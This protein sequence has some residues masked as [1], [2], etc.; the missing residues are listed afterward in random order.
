MVPEVAVGSFVRPSTAFARGRY[1]PF[2][3]SNWMPM[4][5]EQPESPPSSSPEPEPPYPDSV[6]VPDTPQRSDRRLAIGLGVGALMVVLAAILWATRSPGPP[7]APVALEAT[8]TI[9]TG[10]CERVDPSVSLRWTPPESGA[11][12]SGYRL[13]RD[14]SPLSPVIHRSTLSFVDEDVTIGQ[15]YEYQVVALSSEG[16]SP[17]ST[18]IPVTVPTPP[19]EEAHLNGVYEV[20]LTVRRAR[21]I[22]AAFG[23]EDPRR[24]KTRSDRWSFRSSCGPDEGSCPSSWAGLGG[25]IEPTGSR[26]EGRVE[27]VPARCGRGE[28][29]PAPIEI[30]LR[31]TDVDVIDTDWTVTGFEGIVK[32]SFRC[33]GFPKA[34]ATLDVSGSLP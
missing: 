33:P 6:A 3:P 15:E 27:G 20:E 30:E 12:A 17:P 28:K 34:T 7:S 2:I 25:D 29:A 4:D 8:P 5:P 13:I 14:G 23:I 21:S 32:V 24:G 10:S 16:D 1:H 31:A 22:G 26:W 9:C 19:E 11:A 18:A